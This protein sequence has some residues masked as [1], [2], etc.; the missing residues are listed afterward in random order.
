MKKRKT[1][2]SKKPVL[3]LLILNENSKGGIELVKLD[4]KHK[5]SFMAK[6]GTLVTPN[7]EDYNN[8][9]NNELELG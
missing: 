3:N 8:W 1:K 6:F 9:L 5:S 4:L 2:K 7:I